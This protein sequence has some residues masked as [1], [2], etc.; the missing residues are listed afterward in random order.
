MV[1]VVVVAA[2]VS[3]PT[4]ILDQVQP[5]FSRAEVVHRAI[6]CVADRLTISNDF[7]DHT[8]SHELRYMFFF[9][10]ADDFTTRLIDH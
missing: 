5:C 2:V 6:N 8:I 7:F 10:P 9:Q 3:V 4:E 1:V